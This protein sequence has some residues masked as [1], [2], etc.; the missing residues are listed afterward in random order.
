M[1]HS[2][3]YNILFM[4]VLMVIINYIDRGAISYASEQI[5]AEF[6]FNAIAWGAVLGYFGYGYLFGALFGGALAD[7]KGPKFVWIIIGLGWS[8]FVMATAFAGEIGIALFGGSALFGFAFIRILFGFFEGPTF[9]TINKTVANWATPRERGFAVSLGL[10]GTP[11][12][13]MLTAPVAVFLLSVTSWKVMFL[14]LAALGL[15]WVIIW[16]KMFTNLPEEHPKVSKEELEKIRSQSDLLP[17][18]QLVKAEEKSDIRWFHFFKNPTLVFNAI[19]YFAFQYINFL[20]LTWTPKYLQDEFGF[21]LSSLWYLGMIPWIG[22][23][24][25][26]LLGGKLS[27][28][29]RMKTGSLRIARSGLA[30]VSLLL[31]AGCF[32]LIPSAN[33]I[34]GVMVLMTIGNAFNSLPNS[35][36]WS[37][38]IDTEPSKA[39]TFGGI[40]HFITNTATII[41]PTL[42][43]FLVISYGYS[44]MFTAAAVASVIG[45][46]AML[47]VKPGKR[48]PKNIAVV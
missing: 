15:I 33:S 18:E 26:V 43:G 27:D 14:I 37:V 25:T 47:F 48:K 36:Y 42:T 40:T 31:T 9:S 29:L 10:L 17:D 11:L 39:G 13:A 19:G 21:Q 4:M 41:A 5:I 16:T 38:I 1:K 2:Y 28:Y 7:K 44:S 3:R 46:V 35:V 22:A 34:A 6:G 23:C 45:M 20:L 30:V 12:G 24:F 32:M 8:I